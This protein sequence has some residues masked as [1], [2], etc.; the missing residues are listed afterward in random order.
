MRRIITTYIVVVVLLALGFFGVGALASAQEPELRDPM[1]P[2]PFA[3]QKFR[4]AKMASSPKPAQ[5]GAA[6]PKPKPLQLTSIL[7]SPE[8]KIAIIDDQMLAVGDSIRGARLIQLTRARARL[9]RKGKIIN[10]S[11]DD[12]ITAISK[13]AAESNDL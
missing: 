12:G 10:L 3:L 6:A 8:R 4:E 9:V 11:L 13:K 2:P 7:Y 1:Q 5:V